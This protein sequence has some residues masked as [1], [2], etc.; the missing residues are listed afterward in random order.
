MGFLV[1]NNFTPSVNMKCLAIERAIGKQ[2]K[3]S[4]KLLKKV[5]KKENNERKNERKKE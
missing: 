3:C 2:L 5:I 1:A 4:V